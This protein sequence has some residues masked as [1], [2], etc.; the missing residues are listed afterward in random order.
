MVQLHVP[1]SIYRTQSRK[2]FI[3]KLSAKHTY[4]LPILDKQVNRSNTADK[5]KKSR[6][7][8]IILA[9]LFFCVFK[10]QII[11]VNIFI[12]HECT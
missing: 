2:P 4:K 11:G 5:N 7:H 3:G 10:W 9:Y 1:N 8:L 12:I 6:L